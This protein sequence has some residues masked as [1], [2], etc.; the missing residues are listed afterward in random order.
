VHGTFAP[1]ASAAAD[2]PCHGYRA[3]PT[4]APILASDFDKSREYEDWPKVITAVDGMHLGYTYREITSDTPADEAARLTL[5]YPTRIQ[6]RSGERIWPTRL[7]E[8]DPREASS[9]EAEFARCI[10]K[11]TFDAASRIRV[12]A[13]SQAAESK[14]DA[15]CDR[16]VVKQPRWAAPPGAQLDGPEA[17]RPAAAS[18]SRTVIDAGSSRKHRRSVTWPVPTGS[19]VAGARLFRRGRRIKADSRLRRFRV[20]VLACWRGRARRVA[21]SGRLLQAWGKTYT[22]AS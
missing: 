10:P 5:E 19:E 4:T 12:H 14:P 6:G 1:S 17:R 11:D 9:Y 2:H 21:G 7:P 22:G 13:A 15:T 16:A 18:A 3:E 8:T 20:L